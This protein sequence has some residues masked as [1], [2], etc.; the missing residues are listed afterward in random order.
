MSLTN[1]RQLENTRVKLRRL[2][3]RYERLL[4]APSPDTHVRD[5]TLRSLKAMIN[6]MREEITVFKSRRRARSSPPAKA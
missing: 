2:E 5:L 4:K 1:E 3:A 6:Q